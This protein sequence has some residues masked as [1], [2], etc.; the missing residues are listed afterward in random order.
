[1]AKR[2]AVIPV[3]TGMK[4]R[5]KNVIPATP[6]LAR[7]RWE[8]FR[9]DKERF[10]T[11]RNDRTTEDVVSLSIDPFPVIP[12]E[13]GIHFSEVNLD[14]RFSRYGKKWGTVPDGTAPGKR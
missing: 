10:R 4:K 11:S 6:Y 14:T 2:E 12:A 5:R 1:M 9:K 8:S 13:A 7:G 3:K